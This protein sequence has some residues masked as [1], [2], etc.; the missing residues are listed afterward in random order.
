MNA[1][2]ADIWLDALVAKASV[3]SFHKTPRPR[4]PLLAA[5]NAVYLSGVSPVAGIDCLPA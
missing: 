2:Y 3:M 1:D 5:Y 4:R